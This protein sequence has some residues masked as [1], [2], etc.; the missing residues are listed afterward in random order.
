MHVVW[1]TPLN[2][3]DAAGTSL[4]IGFPNNTFTGNGI[5][6]PSGSYQVRWD[7]AMRLAQQLISYTPMIPNSGNHELEPQL[8]GNYYTVRQPRCCLLNAFVHVDS[9]QQND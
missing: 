2:G 5:Q 9:C 7:S 1:L 8:H 4:V 3:L 6:S